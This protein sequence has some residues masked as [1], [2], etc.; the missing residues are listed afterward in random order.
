MHRIHSMVAISTVV[1]NVGIGCSR[2]HLNNTNAYSSA[3]VERR[4]E[5]SQ[6]G[7]KQ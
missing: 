5:I 3:C 4:F 6:T 2:I 1:T 7:I